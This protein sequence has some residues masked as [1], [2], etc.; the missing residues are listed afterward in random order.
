MTAETV[1]LNSGSGLVVTLLGEV[2]PAAL[3]ACWGATGTARV[4]DVDGEV[5]AGG[6][7]ATP[8]PDPHAL[9]SSAI[10][11]SAKDTWVPRRR[12]R[13]CT[14]DGRPGS[15][16]KFV[17]IRAMVAM[18]LLA[19]ALV[20][21]YLPIARAGATPGLRAR[22]VSRVRVKMAPGCRASVADHLAR[23]SGAGQLVTVVAPDYA[24]TR[25]TLVAWHRRKGCWVLALG[26][27]EARIGRRGFS[28]HHEEGDGTTP[29]GSYTIGPVMYGTASDPGVRY[30]YR[31]LVCGDWWDET[32]GSPEYNTFESLP[33]GQSPPFGGSSEALWTETTAYTSFAVIEYNTSPVVPGRGS[34][35]FVHADIG[36]ATEGCVSLRQGELDRLLRWLDPSSSPRIVMA[37][38]SEIERF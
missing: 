35:I 16:E 32:P 8:A 36:A 9:Q 34:A 12:Y 33:C 27:W 19:L 6:G 14:D 29:T 25:A 21:G 17:L 30:R 23:T 7:G 3:E 38:R 20:L 1:A 31:R 22:Q 4:E 26:P 24:A 28:N 11:T 10:A 5:T 13:R 18:A 2:V 37:P 15:V